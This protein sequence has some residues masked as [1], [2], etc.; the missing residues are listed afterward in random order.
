MRRCIF[1]R[2]QRSATFSVKPNSPARF[3]RSGAHHRSTITFSSFVAQASRLWGARAS[4]LRRC[5]RS[6]ARCLRAPQP[7][8][9]CYLMSSRNAQLIRRRNDARV[10]AFS[11]AGQ[12]QFQTARIEIRIFF[13][14]VSF[15]KKND[16]ARSNAVENFFGH[17]FR[18]A[19]D[20]VEPSHRPADQSQ[21]ASRKLRVHEEI[22]HAR[23]CAEKSLRTIRRAPK[24]LSAR[25]D[26]GRDSPR[27]RAPKAPARMRVSM[28]RDL[29]AARQNFRDE[30]RIALRVCADQKESG[31]RVEALEEIENLWR[32]NRGRPVMERDPDLRIFGF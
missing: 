3:A 5:A 16:R 7:G 27:T 4:S 10:T 25:I 14:A 12:G 22:L 26:L 1:L 6:Q 23:R 31:A 13:H 15:M 20:R 11:Q 19:P 29:V 8:W 24:Q 17:Q 28:I 9:L 21:A 18:I 30:M 2:A 32:V